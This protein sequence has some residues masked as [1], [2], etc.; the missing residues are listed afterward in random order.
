MSKKEKSFVIVS[1]IVDVVYSIT[2]KSLTVASLQYEVILL[3][4]SQEDPRAE[5]ME[6]KMYSF[7]WY[8]CDLHC[9]R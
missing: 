1:V 7:Q 6:N 8:K 5:C 4:Y 3:W 9:H 2:Q